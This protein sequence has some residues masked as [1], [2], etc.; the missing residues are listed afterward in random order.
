L[1]SRDQFFYRIA[2]CGIALVSSTPGFAAPNY[3]RAGLASWYGPREAGRRTASGRIFDPSKISAAHR[4]LPLG[5]CVRVTR[6]SNR[7][8]IIVPIIDRGPY[9]D[10]R[11]LD[12]SQAAAEKL[13]MI[14]EG[15]ARVRIALAACPGSA[16]IQHVM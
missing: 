2:L 8:S 7:K 5:S 9:I 1:A 6:F 12:L 11:L 13:G 16:S 3:E 15:L 10:G 14:R 4:T